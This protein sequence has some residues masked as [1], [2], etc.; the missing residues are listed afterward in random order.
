[1]SPG[2]RPA[3]P[4]VTAAPPPGDLDPG[5]AEAVAGVLAD[6][7]T[8]VTAVAELR[9]RDAKLAVDDAGTGYAGLQH[10]MVLRPDLVKLDRARC[11]GRGGFVAGV[12]RGPMQSPG[13]VVSLRAPRSTRH[14]GRPSW[15]MACLALWR[16]DRIRPTAVR[17]GSD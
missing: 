3:D 7:P 5:W 11:R 15:P 9:P 13:T 12:V 6:Y 2:T 1:M 4:T 16:A 14:R 8:L 17:T 10:L